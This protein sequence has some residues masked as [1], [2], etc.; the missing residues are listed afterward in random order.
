LVI[1]L[2]PIIGVFGFIPI[3]VGLTYLILGYIKGG[4]T[5]LSYSKNYKKI[6]YLLLII[7]LMI[8]TN[9]VLILYLNIYSF[10]EEAYTAIKI[11]I[12]TPSNAVSS[13]HIMFGYAI[14]LLYS[15]MYVGNV[16]SQ[17]FSPIRLFFSVLLFYQSLPI[18]LYPTP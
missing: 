12:N 6:A 15:N 8:I 10:R 18:L 9:I 2:I 1:L 17:P 14:Y 3:L 4:D 7:I 13:M 5:T 16:F 11:F